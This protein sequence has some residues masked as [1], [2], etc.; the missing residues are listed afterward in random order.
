[1]KKEKLSSINPAVLPAVTYIERHLEENYDVA[2]LADLC[3]LS[4]SHFL[5]SF[6]KN[7]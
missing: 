2:F 7:L 6:Y 3:H 5:Q 1:M 4:E